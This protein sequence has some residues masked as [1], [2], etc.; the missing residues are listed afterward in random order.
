ML[1]IDAGRLNN[2]ELAIHNAITEKAKTDKPLRITEA[3]KICGVSPSK[4]SKFVNKL[5]FKNYKSYLDFLC[6]KEHIQKKEPEELRRLKESLE[7][8]DMDVANNFF[9]LLNRYDR[10]ILFG[11]GP[12]LFCAQYFEYKLKIITQKFIMAVN[13]ET[14]VKTLLNKETL[15]VVFSTTGRFRSFS[16]ICA[17]AREKKSGCVLIAEE[18]N[19]K[20]LNDHNN[21][22]FLTK[23]FQKDSLA[24]YEKSRALFFIF[25]EVVLQQLIDLRSNE[26][27]DHP[28]DRLIKG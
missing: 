9:D 23:S 17:Y 11:Y 16:E 15:L 21:V 24:P 22:I 10:V 8:F 2:L 1:N 27:K 6:G 25:I 13:E 26:R 18:Y 5:G 14:T 12:S 3:A 19:T 7:N 20:L 4:I 28:N